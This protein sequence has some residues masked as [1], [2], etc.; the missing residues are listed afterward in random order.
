MHGHQLEFFDYMSEMTDEKLKEL[1][2]FAL[3]VEQAQHHLKFRKWCTTCGKALIKGEN[4]KVSV[5]AQYWFVGH[6]NC[7]VNKLINENEKAEKA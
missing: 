5:T 4:L 7:T 1:K 2:Q 3:N 6:I